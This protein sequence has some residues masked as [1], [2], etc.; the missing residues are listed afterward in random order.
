M[1]PQKV[2][3][4]RRHLLAFT[5]RKPVNAAAEA[6]AQAAP[7]AVAAAKVAPHGVVLPYKPVVKRAAPAKARLKVVRARPAVAAA[8]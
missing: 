6:V 3:E 1:N 8:R 2:A 7:E 5:A 4:M